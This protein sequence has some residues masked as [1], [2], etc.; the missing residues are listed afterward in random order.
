MRIDLE[1]LDDAIRLYY[2]PN[3][4]VSVYTEQP[5]PKDIIGVAGEENF[6]ENK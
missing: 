3:S 6:N 4:G 5:I 1:K 2:D